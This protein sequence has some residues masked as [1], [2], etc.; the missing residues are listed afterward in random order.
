VKVIK[1][2]FYYLIGWLLAPVKPRIVLNEIPREI[3]VCSTKEKGGNTQDSKIE[4]GWRKKQI[5]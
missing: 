5:W 4:R 2:C 1:F 3:D